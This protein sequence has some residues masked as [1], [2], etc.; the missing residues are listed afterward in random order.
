MPASD[1]LTTAERD[2]FR[3]L[4]ADAFPDMVEILAPSG[5]V[6]SRGNRTAGEQVIA[7]MPGELRAEGMRPQ[8][9]EVASRLGWAAAYAVDLPYDAPV[10]A[11]HRLRIAGRVF[12]VGAVLR[13]GA[14]GLAAT[15]ICAERGP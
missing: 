7:V 3:A 10:E 4:V 6:D 13:D 5:A 12:E 15:A 1:Y 8:E 11:R 2:A 9:R 14:W